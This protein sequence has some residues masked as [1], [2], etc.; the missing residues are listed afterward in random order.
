MRR[1]F[2][3]LV[4]ILGA[5]SVVAAEAVFKNGQPCMDGLCIGDGLAEVARIKWDPAI[6]QV[7]FEPK[8]PIASLKVKDKRKAEIERIYRGDLGKAMPFLAGSAF[9]LSAVPALKGLAVCEHRGGIVGTFTGQDGNPTQVGL[10]L[11][12]DPNDSKVQRWTVTN[13]ERHF[14]NAKTEQ[15]QDAVRAQMDKLYAAAVATDVKPRQGMY[16]M[17]GDRVYLTMKVEREA[18]AALKT[19]PLCAAGT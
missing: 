1:I 12:P 18:Y 8:E 14:V 6:V 7:P 5:Q 17:S 4:S 9:D 13:F 19:H 11:L 15:Q 3:L 2:V 16:H 10:K